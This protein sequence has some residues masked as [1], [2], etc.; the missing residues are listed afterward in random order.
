MKPSFEQAL[1][2]VWRQ[3]LVENAKLVELDGS[4]YPVRRTPKRSLRQVDFVFDSNEIRG[5]EQ[6]PDTRSEWAKR[7]STRSFSVR[8]AASIFSMSASLGGS[9]SLLSGLGQSVFDMRPLFAV[10]IEERDHVREEVL[11][12]EHGLVLALACSLQS[13]RALASDLVNVCDLAPGPEHF[14]RAAVGAVGLRALVL[15]DLGEIGIDRIREP[16]AAGWRL[17]V[18][19][20]RSRSGRAAELPGVEFRI[21]ALGRPNGRDRV[22]APVLDLALAVLAVSDVEIP[23]ANDG[24]FLAADDRGVG[25]RASVCMVCDCDLWR[26]VVPR[27]DLHTGDEL[28]FPGRGFSPFRLILR[29]GEKPDFDLATKTASEATNPRFIGFFDGW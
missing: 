8:Q 16:G 25:L 18:S 14:E 15:V 10:P 23:D 21:L 5:L 28:D 22:A 4:R 17:G 20:R 13:Q 9:Y 29:G 12:G 11:H 2:E 7:T 3:A 26:V 24:D 1:I 27:A 19:R 6:N